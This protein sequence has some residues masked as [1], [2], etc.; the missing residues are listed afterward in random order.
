MTPLTGNRVLTVPS[1]TSDLVGVLYVKEIR[2]RLG[3]DAR[4]LRAGKI[5]NA[6]IL[7][8]LAGLNASSARAVVQEIA[9]QLWGGWY[10]REYLPRELQ[11]ESDRALE[12]GES[13]R[14]H[15]LRC[16]AAAGAASQ[17]S[18]YPKGSPEL[19]AAL[20]EAVAAAEAI[21]GA[22]EVRK[23]LLARIGPALGGYGLG[24]PFF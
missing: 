23:Y 16:V 24:G 18:R 14:C 21:C 4:E 11:A 19:A 8:A 15:R 9:T 10:W 2:R 22:E 20:E 3:A 7:L 17:A 13:D 6:N 1:F 12:A 5:R